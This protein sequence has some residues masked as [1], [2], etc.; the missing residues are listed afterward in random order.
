MKDNIGNQEVMQLNLH[1]FVK[2]NY[3]NGNYDFAKEN[4]Q[5][6]HDETLKKETDDFTMGYNQA[7]QDY[8]SKHRFKHYPYKLTALLNRMLGNKLSEIVNFTDGYQSA[9]KQIKR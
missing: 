6:F 7:M 3:E 8:Q 5:N 2:E 4:Y 1:D 9:K